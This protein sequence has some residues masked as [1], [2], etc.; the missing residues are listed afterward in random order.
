MKINSFLATALAATALGSS[1]AMAQTDWEKDRARY[2]AIMNETASAERML[3][4][5]VTNGFNHIGDVQNLVLDPTG[6]R[7]EYVLYEVPYPYSTFGDEDGFVR[8]D[9]VAIEPGTVGGLDLAIDDG[10]EPYAKNELEI[11]RAEADDRLVNRI[12]ESNMMFS[13]GSM[14][15][16]SDIIFDPDNGMV[17]H[18]V[19]EFDDDSLFDEDERLIPADWVSL[20]ERRGYWTVS[21]PL[22]YDYEI[23][24]Y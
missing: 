1:P 2:E 16:I 23:W 22:N 24:V 12:I 19:V 9:N 3:S 5:D 10:T 18:Y 7:I 20:D 15:E 8:W 17:T 14:R 4:G 11:T 6:T 21:Q 13:D